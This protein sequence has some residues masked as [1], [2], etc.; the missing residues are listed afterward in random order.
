MTDV[1]CL[2]DV[3]NFVNDYL[4]LRTYQA[5]DMFH[6]ILIQNT[7]IENKHIHDYFNSKAHLVQL[8]WGFRDWYIH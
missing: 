5:L 7:K 8:N 2:F 6:K 4:A 3:F 1:L